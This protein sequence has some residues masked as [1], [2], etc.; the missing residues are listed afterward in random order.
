MTAKKL[1]YLLLAAVFVLALGILG[2]G[3][4]AD[5]VLTSRAAKLSKLKAESEATQSLQTLLQKNKADL[6]RYK[7]LNEIAKAVVP[8]DKDQAQT[9][10]EVVKIAKESGIS[11]LS[12][13][14]FP[15]S[16]LGGATTGPTAPS[17][18]AGLTQVTPVK[19][20]SGVYMLP[21]TITVEQPHAVTYSQ[22]TAFLQKLEQNRRT[23]Q[24]SDISL[25]PD[26]LRLNS[27]SFSLVL[28]EYI[29][30]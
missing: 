3:Y 26:P 8:Q 2:V 1:Y 10:R 13:V 19:G 7:E 29:K 28:N 23:A 11:G 30:P 22:F 14:T 16:T 21:I 12:S 25:K 20:I 4:A 18:T 15:A 27:L 9:V 6:V 17:T 24:V 5:V